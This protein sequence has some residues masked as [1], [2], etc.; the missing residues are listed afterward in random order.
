MGAYHFGEVVKSQTTYVAEL[1]E[2]VSWSYAGGRVSQGFAIAM[3]LHFIAI[4]YY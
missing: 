3:R 2:G 4:F 1:L